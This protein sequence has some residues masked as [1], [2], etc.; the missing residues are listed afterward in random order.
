MRR[1]PAPEA[2][3]PPIIALRDASLRLGDRVVFRHTDWTLRAGEHWALV[4]PSGGGKSVF[5]AALAGHL[6]VTGGE[7]TGDVAEREIALVSF[8]DQHEFSGNGPAG[9]RWFTLEQDE[10]PLLRDR[11]ALERIEDINPFEVGARP[12]RTPAAFA[13][14]R[15]ALM[16][17]LGIAHLLDRPLLALSHGERMKSLLTAALL[18]RPRVLVF[19]DPFAG[20][21]AAS[22]ND[23]RRLIEGIIREGRVSVV[24]AATREDEL[25]R[26]LNRVAHIAGCRIV[27]Q[28]A[29]HIA[30][31]RAARSEAKRRARPRTAARAGEPE[32]LSLR[33]VTVR[34]GRTVILR[35]V[36]W[37]VRRGEAWAVAGPNGSGKTTLLSLIDGTHP[38]AYAN[39]LRVFGLVRGRDANAWDIRARIGSVSPDVHLQVD[40][41]DS[42][43]SVVWTG[44]QSTAGDDGAPPPAVQRRARA[45]LRRFGLG[46]AADATFGALPTGRQRL[47]LLARALVHDPELLLLDEPLQGLDR[48]QRRVFRAHVAAL[49]RDGHT[50]L[51][52]SHHRD[53]W[54]D[55]LDGVL[56]LDGRG[57]V[58]VAK[59]R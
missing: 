59:F 3:V 1:S 30:P 34:Y 48:E 45:L 8:D 6:P 33:G 12:S 28:R 57:G 58:R 41:A 14:E 32:V 2:A 24:V 53:D 20:L 15:A 18:R 37:Q 42:L 39:D 22:R 36:D 55:G 7:R 4:G 10:A 46:R 49:I 31:A 47:V 56:Q 43:L 11:L 54:P 17:R 5:A 38:Q 25:P 44:W 51:Y 40:P 19:D 16:K 35:D 27:S 23:F 52:V 50:V 29:L 13:R 9:T 21:D 26:G